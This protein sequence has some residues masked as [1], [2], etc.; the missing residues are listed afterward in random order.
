MSFVE[1]AAALRCIRDDDDDDY[2]G[3]G[4]GKGKGRDFLPAH[5]GRSGTVVCMAARVAKVTHQCA[6]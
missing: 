1:T 3:R 6:M 5:I 2:E 4:Q